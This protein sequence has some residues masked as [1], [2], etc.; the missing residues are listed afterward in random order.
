MYPPGVE[1]LRGFKPRPATDTVGAARQKYNWRAKSRRAI[2][3]VMRPQFPIANSEVR[4]KGQYPFRNTVLP[5]YCTPQLTP[6][7]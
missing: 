7:S 2:R 6:T 5:V 4:T 1:S 3:F